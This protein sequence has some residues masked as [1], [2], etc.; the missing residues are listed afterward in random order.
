MA[1]EIPTDLKARVKASYD[2]I[3]DT[4]N[5]VF[6]N[7]NEAIRLDYLGRLLTKLSSQTTANVLELGCGAGVPATK[8][9]LERSNPVFHVTGNDISTSQLNLARA[10]LS[11]YEDRLTLVESD[12]LSLSF[13]P[14]SFDA[15]TGFY[16]II[17]LPR[18]EQTQLMT[19]I[20]EWVKPGGYLLANFIVTTASTYEEDKW[21][22]HEKGWMFWSGWGEEKSVEMVEKAGFEVEVREVRQAD[23]DEAF[24]WVLARKVEK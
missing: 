20:A 11:A 3:A 8:F 14:A 24:V 17:H 16:S 4:Y 9:L 1:H 5:A 18:E 13:P 12:M 7:P 21:L 10:N 2:A 6:T 19:K 15:V 22:G 23:G